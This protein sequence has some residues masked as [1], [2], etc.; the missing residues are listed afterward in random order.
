MGAPLWMEPDVNLAQI[1]GHRLFRANAHI[2]PGLQP[3]L[4]VHQDVT[5][6][7]VAPPGL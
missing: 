3:E 1:T 2:Y 6:Q 5:P 7:H 4:G